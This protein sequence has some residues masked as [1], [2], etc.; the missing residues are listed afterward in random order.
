MME[1]NT[2]V[3]QSD[4]CKTLNALL[5]A[6]TD[7]LKR[8]RDKPE[9]DENFVRIEHF[10]Q[11]A[12]EAGAFM[13]LFQDR[14]T[15]QGVMDF[16]TNLLR[17]ADRRPSDTTL[18][19][20]DASQVP[21]LANKQFLRRLQAATEEW[22]K[23]DRKHGALWTGELLQQAEELSLEVNLNRLEKEFLKAS[24]N[25]EQEHHDTLLRRSQRMWI[26]IAIG[27][28]IIIALLVYLYTPLL[29]PL[30]RQSADDLLMRAKTLIADREQGL[31]ANEALTQQTIELAE[32]ARWYY[33]Q[34][35]TRSTDDAAAYYGRAQANKALWKLLSSGSDP[36]E[37]DAAFASA[38]ADANLAFV[39]HYACC[40]VYHFLGTMDYDSLYYSDARQHFDEAI[41][42]GQDDAEVYLAYANAIVMSSPSEK[43]YPDALNAYIKAVLR[44]EVSQPSLLP[45]AYLKLTDLYMLMSKPAHALDCLEQ[46]EANG[47]PDIQTVTYRAAIEPMLPA[48]QE[49]NAECIPPEA[50]N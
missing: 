39:L 1:E 15:A 34:A 29:A 25:I 10:L 50:R 7:L 5:E 27:A 44:A 42:C 18:A 11:E 4:G 3:E 43:E 14:M 17:S 46:A 8:Y 45:M 23:L 36:G 19:D 35:I 22:Q 9:A 16:W 41:R 37:A 21:D 30:Y 38:Q 33:T 24:R 28:S 49:E 48:P 2:I 31:K 32:A 12:R 20:F 26:A 13:D 6:H 47:A 40:E